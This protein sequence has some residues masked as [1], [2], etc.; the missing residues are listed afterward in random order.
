MHTS[1]KPTAQIFIVIKERGIV[2]FLP[3][4]HGIADEQIDIH[5][6]Q[7]RIKKDLIGGFC[8]DFAFLNSQTCVPRFHASADT[9]SNCDAFISLTAEKPRRT[10]NPNV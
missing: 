6:A 2:T 7:G 4:E 8:T 9:V 1:D 5:P 3:V 10:P